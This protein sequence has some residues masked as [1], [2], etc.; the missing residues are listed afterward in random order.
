MFG[1]IEKLGKALG[2]ISKG[3]RTSQIGAV[4]VE[5]Q[6]H[7][8]DGETQVM[9]VAQHE[10]IKWCSAAARLVLRPDGTTALHTGFA[11]D[12]IPYALEEDLPTQTECVDALEQTLRDMTSDAAEAL[13]QNYERSLARLRSRW[14]DNARNGYSVDRLSAYKSF[15]TRFVV[16]APSTAIGSTALVG[17]EYNE[18]R[19]SFDRLGSGSQTLSNLVPISQELLAKETKMSGHEKLQ[20][21][22][23]DETPF[24]QQ[25]KD[26]FLNSYDRTRRYRE[27]TRP[28][29]SPDAVV[30]DG[31]YNR[32][33]KTDEVSLDVHFATSDRIYINISPTR[34]PG[35]ESNRPS[36]FQLSLS[37]AANRFYISTETGTIP[38]KNPFKLAASWSSTKHPPSQEDLMTGLRRLFREIAELDPIWPEWTYTACD[39]DYDPD[40]PTLLG[41]NLP[42]RHQPIIAKLLAESYVDLVA[43]TARRIGKHEQSM[44]KLKAAEVLP[45]EMPDGIVFGDIKT[46][47]L[48]AWEQAKI[49]AHARVFMVQ[50]TSAPGAKRCKRALIPIYGVTNER[51][52]T[53]KQIV[54]LTPYTK[55]DALRLYPAN[56]LG[57]VDRDRLEAIFRVALTLKDGIDNP[58]LQGD[59]AI[60]ELETTDADWKVQWTDI[61]DSQGY[62]LTAFSVFRDR[63]DRY[64]KRFETGAGISFL[65]TPQGETVYLRPSF[66]TG[67]ETLMPPEEL[68]WLREA[69]DQSFPFEPEKAETMIARLDAE[70][71]K[72]APDYP[73][74]PSEDAQT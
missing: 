8:R 26:A 5:T 33:E 47:R 31:R 15:H 63:S 35:E 38:Q 43:Q 34:R 74:A 58:L 30:Q 39:A 4:T 62:A 64:Y 22:S 25:A 44:Q 56:F 1:F 60:A 49:P 70:W 66:R 52:F 32:E 6:S 50:T 10:T 68:D 54:R 23:G 9:L 72:L 45:T 7:E 67:T 16:A 40:H 73:S 11:I 36:F 21:L 13:R 71:A 12:H 2:T 55:P 29:P 69:I 65:T 57:H 19:Q 3:P 24:L 61:P 53:P 18:Y 59:C 20:L 28:H 27:Q 14:E 42:P 41:L 48:K 37:L 46:G 51:P 17:V